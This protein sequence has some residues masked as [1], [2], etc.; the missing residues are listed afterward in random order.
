MAGTQAKRGVSLALSGGG[1]RATLFHLGSLWRL[2]ELGWLPKLTEVT[3]VSGGSIISAFLGLHWKQLSFQ[4]NVATN[5]ETVIAKPIQNFCS[6]TIDIGAV[7]KGF[8]TPF[9]HTSDYVIAEY[10]KRLYGKTTLQNLPAKG[11]GPLFTI[12]GT[13]LQTGASIRFSRPYM[14]EYHLG[15]IRSPS[16]SL[17]KAVACSSGFPPVLCPVMIKSEPSSWEEFEGADL[18]LNK[19]MKSTMYVG[20]GGIYD[21]LGL[22][23]AWDYELVLV[24]DAGAP[25]TV[26]PSPTWLKFSMVARTKRTLDIIDNQSRSLRKRMLIRDF[27]SQARKGAYWSIGSHVKDYELEK[28]GLQPIVTDSAITAGLAKMRTRLNSFSKQEQGR[29]INWGYAMADTAMRRH[30]LS[31]SDGQGGSWPLP[32]YALNKEGG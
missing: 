32:E 17:A 30:I 14:A 29:L 19:D 1:F 21:N 2:N 12:Y 23:R 9:K 26:K 24:S 3:S 16:I 5:F 15:K 25:F 8:L 7:V 11:E 31:A 18:F 4:N 6:K 27:Q 10:E 28:Q 20:D 22:E 13:S